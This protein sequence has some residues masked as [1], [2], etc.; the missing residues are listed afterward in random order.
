MLSAAISF[1]VVASSWAMYIPHDPPEEY[2][3]DPPEEP[4]PI[5]PFEPLLFRGFNEKPR[6]IV[7]LSAISGEHGHA[8]NDDEHSG[9]SKELNSHRFPN[10]DQNYIP[11]PAN[12][13]NSKQ[14]AQVINNYYIFAKEI[15]K[16]F[17]VKNG[18]LPWSPPARFAK[19]GDFETDGKAIKL[20]E[21][22]TPQEQ[23]N[24]PLNVEEL[25]KD[26][27]FIRAF[28]QGLGMLFDQKI[29][30]IDGGPKTTG[31]PAPVIGDMEESS[32]GAAQPFVNKTS[33]TETDGED[34]PPMEESASTPR[35]IGN[36][37]TPSQN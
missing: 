11:Q 9:E 8:P 20:P 23:P 33:E 1:L 16:L 31:N 13:D 17:D 29:P 32:N 2:V 34:P 7:P 6:P 15:A 12:M 37:L 14:S 27:D 36:I 10:S 26:P 4:I 5:N 3:P 25:L 18:A 21:R 30:E 19:R 22:V 35:S 24:L 28:N